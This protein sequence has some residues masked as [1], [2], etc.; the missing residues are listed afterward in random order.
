MKIADKTVVNLHFI[1]G[2]SAKIGIGLAVPVAL[3][4]VIKTITVDVHICGPEVRRNL[5]N[6]PLGFIIST[7]GVKPQTY[8]TETS[9]ISVDRRLYGGVGVDLVA[10]QGI[11]SFGSGS[12]EGCDRVG[13]VSSEPGEW[14][15]TG[16]FIVGLGVEAARGIKSAVSERLGDGECQCGREQKTGC[17][18]RD[19]SKH[20][21]RTACKGEC[22]G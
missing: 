12:R 2:E 3:A 1:G 22:G 20:D 9:P 6:H 16:R 15:T 8:T 4:L 5:L 21:E 7:E 13:F 17:D 14:G 11:F 19:G 10:V 18:E